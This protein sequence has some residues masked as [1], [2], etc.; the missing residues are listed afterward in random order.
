LFA[1]EAPPAPP[2]EPPTAFDV[3][4]ERRI[5]AEAETRRAGAAGSGAAGDALLAKVQV[6]CAHAAHRAGGR[7]QGVLMCAPLRGAVVC[8]GC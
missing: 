1:E 7:L 2:G 6:S 4:H 3:S 8:G 5:I